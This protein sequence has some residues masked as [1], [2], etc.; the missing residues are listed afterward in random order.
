MWDVKENLYKF[1]KNPQ[2][3]FYLNYVGC[4][5]F[6]FCTC[7]SHKFNS[8]TLTMWDVKWLSLPT[9]TP[10]VPS[11]T[12]TMWDVKVFVFI[13]WYIQLQFYLNYVGCKAQKIPY[14]PLF[15]FKSFTLTMWDV[16]SLSADKSTLSF[17]RF[18]LTMWDVKSTCLANYCRDASVLP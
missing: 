2:K 8:F 1:I 3:S 13:V 10:V 15:S 11:F 12:L 9:R 18:T 7:N 14:Y 16:K 5:V 4:K 17:L 6:C